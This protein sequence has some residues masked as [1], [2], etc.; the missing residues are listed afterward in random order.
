[1]RFV[2]RVATFVLNVTVRCARDD[3]WTRAMRNEMQFI[4]NDWSALLWALGSAAA[5][6]RTSDGLAKSIRGGAVGI[7]IATAI[8]GCWMA[9]I[10]GAFAFFKSYAE[11]TPLL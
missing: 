9:I 8:G 1:M 3:D 6:L 7:C 4:S 10:A 5:I 11:Q 2:R